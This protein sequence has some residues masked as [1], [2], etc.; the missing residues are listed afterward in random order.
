STGL[1]SDIFPDFPRLGQD[2]QAIYLFSNLFTQST[3]RY[4]YEQWSF[5]PKQK[6]YSGQDFSYNAYYPS[7]GNIIPDSTQPANVWNPY[8]KPRAEF[9]VTSENFNSGC[10]SSPGPAYNVCSFLMVWAISNALDVP[11]GLGLGPEVS[12]A[13]ASPTYYYTL[14]PDASQPNSGAFIGT[15]D[16]RISGQVSYGAGS[17]YA[18][19]TT[20]TA[21]GTAGALLFKIQPYLNAGNQRC[22]IFQ[23]LCPDITSETTITD[24]I[25][26]YGNSTHAFYPTQQ[27]DVEGNVTTV[28][29]LSGPS[30]YA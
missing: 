5:L 24:Q 9:A 16:Q 21:A 3:G 14:P 1:G 10:Y 4:N 26:Y 30:T 20:G 19:L 12:V 7:Y 29:N 17:L 25:L 6:M 2:T 8:D 27:P 22:G 15:G 23:A 28:L 18:A 13:F 11:P